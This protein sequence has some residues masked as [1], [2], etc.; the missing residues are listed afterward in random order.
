MD[1]VSGVLPV[2]CGTPAWHRQHADLLI[3]ANGLRWYAG[4]AS[5]LT[6]CQWSFHGCSP[7]CDLSAQ[8]GTR[9][10]G[11]KVKGYQAKKNR[12]H[13]TR[14]RRCAWAVGQQVAPASGH[15]GD[16]WCDD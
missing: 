16:G 1:I 4:S 11:W 10:T 14:C 9:S 7:L 6:N 13:T 5:Q 8:K 3:V 2:P 12:P 15:A